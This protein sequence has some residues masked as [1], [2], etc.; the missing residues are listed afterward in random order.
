M[1]TGRSISFTSLRQV[2]DRL[3]NHSVHLSRISGVPERSVANRHEEGDEVPKVS[4]LVSINDDH[5]HRFSE[6]VRDVEDA[7]MEIEEKMEDLG[8]LTGSIDSEKVEPLRRLEGVSHVEESRRVEIPPPDS[9]I[10]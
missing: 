3:F 2:N 7:G 8:V 5:L 4:L 10:Q 6:V 9:D 1:D